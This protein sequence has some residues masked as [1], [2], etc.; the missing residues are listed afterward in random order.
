MLFRLIEL[1]DFLG[2]FFSNCHKPSYVILDSI[3]RS[4]NPFRHYFSSFDTLSFIHLFIFGLICSSSIHLRHPLSF[5]HSFW[6]FLWITNFLWTLVLDFLYHSFVNFGHFCLSPFIANILC[7]WPIHF[8]PLPFTSLSLS[9]SLSPF[10]TKASHLQPA[11][12]DEPVLGLRVDLEQPVDVLTGLVDAVHVEQEHT[13]V[14]QSLET[15]AGR[16]FYIA[17]NCK[18]ICD[19]MTVNIASCIEGGSIAS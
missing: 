16:P 4:S 2:N 9:L 5:N 10:G 18:S 17:T 15:K 13:G 6:T 11:L 3:C 7:Y 1:L 14:V 12:E 19:L 8:S